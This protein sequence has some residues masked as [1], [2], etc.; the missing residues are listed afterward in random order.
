MIIVIVLNFSKSLE[1]EPN[2]VGSLFGLATCY[3]HLG[4]KNKSLEV[5]N[6]ILKI[7]HKL[8][9]VYRLISS[10]TSFKTDSSLISRIE[11]LLENRKLENWQKADLY[12]SLSKGFDDLGDYKKSFEYCQKGNMLK[13][14]DLEYNI[15]KD[16]KLFQ[17]LKNVSKI[18]S[19]INFQSLNMK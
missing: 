13:R 19:S 5:T 10:M 6:K 7:D 11:E 17:V 12:F 15:S 14:S 18:L 3:Q 16:R 1:L 4:E 9:G 2:H 8:T